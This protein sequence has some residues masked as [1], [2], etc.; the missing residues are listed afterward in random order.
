M[1]T[2]EVQFQKSHF[3]GESLLDV[4]MQQALR[5]LHDLQI[6]PG[7]VWGKAASNPVH[8]PTTSQPRE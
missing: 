5:P 2:S 6:F 4:R 1:P 8:L 7:D 3:Q